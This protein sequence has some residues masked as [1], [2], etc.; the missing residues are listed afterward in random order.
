MAAVAGSLSGAGAA[1]LPKGLVI[2]SWLLQIVVALILLQ[3]LYFKFTGAPESKYIFTQMGMEPWGR[4]AS[5]VVELIAAVLLL[6]PPTVVYGAILSAG[7]ISGAIMSHLTKLG[8]TIPNQDGTPGN[9]G[10]LLFGLALVVL[11]GSAV[12]LAVHR[13][14]IPIIGARL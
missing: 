9:D 2:A 14:E 1:G 6:V 7:V 10:G 4:I 12:V 3:T 13:R 11:V 5:G 8:I